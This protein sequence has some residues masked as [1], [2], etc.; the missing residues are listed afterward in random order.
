MHQDAV[1]A[2]KEGARIIML[3]NFSPTIR[4]QKQFK[5]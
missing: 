1:L 5:F 3:D 2:A 4:L